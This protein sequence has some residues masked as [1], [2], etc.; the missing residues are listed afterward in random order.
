MSPE[1]EPV[2]A[3]AQN[4]RENAPGWRAYMDQH[5]MDYTWLSLP[6]QGIYGNSHMLMMDNNN[7]DIAAL[8]WK[9]LD[10]K[11]LGTVR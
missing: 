7:A 3:W 9:W 1:Y 6:E 2:H 8:I 5:G 11:G 10:Q 4:V